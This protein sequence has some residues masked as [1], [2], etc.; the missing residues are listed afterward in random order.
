VNTVKDILKET[1]VDP[2]TMK[3]K[4]EHVMDREKNHIPLENK[5]Q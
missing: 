2:V 3:W 5:N 4:E 1:K